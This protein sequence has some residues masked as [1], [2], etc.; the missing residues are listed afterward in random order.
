MARNE[1]K[2]LGRLNRYYLKR[3]HDGKKLT[4]LKKKARAFI[5]IPYINTPSTGLCRH[6]LRKIILRKVSWFFYTS[7]SPCAS[8]HILTG[9]Y[10]NIYGFLFLNF[11]EETRSCWSCSLIYLGWIALAPKANNFQYISLLLHN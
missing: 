4:S 8:R 7:A 11:L 2:Q 3:Q 9:S 10:F 5:Y 6:P 1:E